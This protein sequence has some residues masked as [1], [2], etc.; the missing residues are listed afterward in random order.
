MQ[1][2]PV[3]LPMTEN[4]LSTLAGCASTALNTRITM[5]SSAACPSGADV[6]LPHYAQG[7][8]CLLSLLLLRRLGLHPALR[9]NVLLCAAAAAAGWLL[10][11]LHLQREAAQARRQAHHR[12][13]VSTHP[14]TK[15]LVHGYC[16]CCM[17]QDLPEHPVG[18]HV[19]TI[20]LTL[21]S[22]TQTC[23]FHSCC[24]CCT[25]LVVRRS[26]AVRPSVGTVGHAAQ[27][28]LQHTFLVQVST[29]CTAAV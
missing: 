9:S 5:L 18:F 2:M 23:T 15:L 7:C 17:V 11:Q 3:L 22:F 29:L 6:V 4:Q 20:M 14:R 19:H 26:L 12:L 13:G 25:S 27:Q 21:T 24:D 8:A 16:C 10:C 1:Y 28:A